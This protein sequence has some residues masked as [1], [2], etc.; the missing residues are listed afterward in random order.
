AICASKATLQGPCRIIPQEY[1]NV[2]CRNIDIAW[3]AIGDASQNQLA[4]AVA[5]ELLS[6]ELDLE[7]SYREGKRYVRSFEPLRVPPVEPSQAGF[8]SQGVYLIT[9]GLGGIG[10]T[11]ADY[12]AREWKAKL[13]LIGRTPLPEREKWREWLETHGI[14][15]A[16]CRKIRGIQ[17]LENVG[18]EVL[19]GS[20][21]VADEARMREILV[22]VHERFGRIDGVIHGAGIVTLD[23]LKAIQQVDQAECNRHFRPK[24]EGVKEL[25]RLLADQPPDFYLL[26]S[27]LSS[28]LG[29]IGFVGYA[30]AN[31]F[32]DAFADQQNQA[33]GTRW[34]SVNWDTWNVRSSEEREEV[35]KLGLDATVAEFAMSTEE[36]V[37]ALV[38]ALGSK[39]ARLV[40]S[41]GRLQGRLDQWIQ[42]SFLRAKRKQQEPETTATLSLYQRP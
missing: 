3:P 18:A 12:L 13:V 33:G 17:G 11:V 25:A 7:V 4:E 37:E 34:Y 21:D 29:G 36:G 20:A 15:D 31:Q 1:S 24:V 22:Q 41:T 28:V 32:L 14:E 19:I 40:H 30:S 35:R 38:R 2:I 16:V 42:G 39:E 10:L 27:S 23:I 6:G 26:L 9:G 8:R 5:K